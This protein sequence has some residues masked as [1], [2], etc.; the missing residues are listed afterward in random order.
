MTLKPKPSAVFGNS[1]T[2]GCG[3]PSEAA[4]AATVAYCYKN[5]VIIIFGNEIET[6]FQLIL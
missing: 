5:K 4:N 3:W 6:K 1:T 2:R